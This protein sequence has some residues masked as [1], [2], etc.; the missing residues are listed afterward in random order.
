L[1]SETQADVS[2]TKIALFSLLGLVASLCLV[3][4]GVGVL[5]LEA[6]TGLYINKARWAELPVAYQA[7]LR[8]A[9]AYALMEML[10]GYD[11]RNPKALNRLVAAGAQLV[12]L[13]PDILKALRTALEQVLDE[14]A[15]K[16]EQ[17]KR[18][19]ENWRAF[20]AEQHRWFLIADARAEMSVYALTT[21]Q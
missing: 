17:F 4:V 9:C 16:S 1:R 19:L 11:A 12:V 18:V 15:A 3:A 8:A 13:S 7:M 2:L 5:E 14:E 6:N 10:A 21:A 20:R